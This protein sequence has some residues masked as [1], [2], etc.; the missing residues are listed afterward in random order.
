MPRARRRPRT[1]RPSAIRPSRRAERRSMRIADERESRDDGDEENRGELRRER[2]AEC[3]ARRRPEENRPPL[4]RE[5]REGDRPEEPERGGEVRVDDGGM[6]EMRR[7]EGDES[8]GA[9]AREIAPP[10]PDGAGHDENEHEEEPVE[11]AP[12]GVE[13]RVRRERI[14]REEPGARLLG[15]RDGERPRDARGPGPRESE[16]EPREELGER[17]VLEIR[18]V[19]PG[20]RVLGP[21]HRVKRLVHRGAVSAPGVVGEERPGQRESARHRPEERP[22][23]AALHRAILI[24]PRVPDRRAPRDPPESGNAGRGEARR[25]RD[26]RLQRREDAAQGVGRDPEGMGGRHHPRGRR[27]PRPDRRGG[28]RNPRPDRRRP[29]EEP[30][31][32]RKPEDLLPDGARARR[33]HLRD[34]PPRPPVRRFGPAGADPA[35]REGLRRRHVREPD[36]RRAPPR[37]GHAEVEVPREHLPDRHRE[38]HLLPLPDGVP[39]GPPRLLAPVPRERE[40]RPPSRT[41]SSSTRRSSRPESGR[42]CG[43]ARCRS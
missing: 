27:L 6:G 36:A 24:G 7:L 43:S 34:G 21:G 10:P 2:G 32:R 19:G 14:A 25:R 1:G 31:L 39:L 4:D 18:E 38:R 20:N 26:A 29:R 13:K 33:R 22:P 8:R 40:P 37:R 9:E 28:A 42:G 17:R 15:R 23:R 30:R 3:G 16:R 11:G 5:E 12:R 41:T 35:D